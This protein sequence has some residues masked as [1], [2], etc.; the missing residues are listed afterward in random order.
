VPREIFRCASSVDVSELS[1]QLWQQNI[2]HRVDV[3]GSW[4]I[5]SVPDHVPLESAAAIVEAWSNGEELTVQVVQSSQRESLQQI[6]DQLFSLPVTSLLCLF[7]LL[8]FAATQWLNWDSLLRW[9]SFQAIFAQGGNLYLEGNFDAIS[10][11]QVWRLITPA[12][13]HFGWMHIAFNTLW[14]IDFGRTIE[15]AQGGFRLVA[16]FLVFALLSNLT[17][18]IF[19]EQLFGGMSGVIYGL[20]GYCFIFNK[21]LPGSLPCVPPALFGFMVIWLLLCMSGLVTMLGFGDIANAAHV[22]GLLSGLAVGALL[23]LGK[24]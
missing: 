7:S 14:L 5:V 21:R 9:L 2:Q 4:Q 3:F 23:P 13:I 15:R 16:L 22:A 12:F 11:G 19:A 18:A 17:Q 8:G 20:L 1:R 6:V 24:R 10:R